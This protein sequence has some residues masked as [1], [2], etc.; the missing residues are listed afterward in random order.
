MIAR[1]RHAATMA[2]LGMALSAPL[3]A[4]EIKPFESG[5]LEKIVT[6][7]KSRPFVLAFWSLACPPCRDELALLGDVFQGESARDLVLVSTDTPEESA[8]IAT[9]LAQRRLAVVEAWVFADAFTERLRYGI[10][11]QWQGE[12][13]RTYLYGVDGKIQAV[14]G[15]LSPQQLRQWIKRQTASAKR[16]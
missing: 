1:L 2:C 6:A 14:S 13:P 3:A 7:H 8:A 11:R 4:Q 10:D 16:P 15:K 9:V 5:S 12:L